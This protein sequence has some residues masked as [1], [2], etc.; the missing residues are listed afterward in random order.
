MSKGEQTRQR[1]VGEA[2]KLLNRTGY[3]STSMSSI[4]NEVGLKKGGLYNHFN[5]KEELAL[6]AF[7]TNVTILGRYLR[8]IAEK[9][10]DPLNV[11][12]DLCDAGMD[13]ASG[14]VIPGGCPVLNAGIESDYISD[15]LKKKATFAMERMCELILIPLKKLEQAQ[16]LKPDTDLKGLAY[17][18]LAT[19]EGSILV[20]KISAE[21]SGQKMVVENL[22]KSI[23]AYLN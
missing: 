1:I 21:K 9:Q 5:S 15:N 8:G 22:K 18:I 4:L 23:E 3:F 19:I 14:E 16:R 10:E 20:S 13:I 17:F 11:L 6:E 12:F 7:T 2:G